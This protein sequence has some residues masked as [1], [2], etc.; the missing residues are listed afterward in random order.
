MRKSIYICLLWLFTTATLSAQISVSGTVIDV[1]D[2]QTIIGVNIIEAGTSNGTISDID[3]NFSMNVKDEN[4]V[5]I[6]SYIGYT[7]KEVIVGQQR[8]FN[9]SMSMSSTELEE[10]VII[11]Y[12][13]VKK[14][15]LT[16]SV[17]VIDSKVIDEIKPVKAEEALQ[18]TMTGVN[19]TQQSGAPGAG[20]DIRIRGIA[21]N[22]DGRPTVI[23]DGYEGDLSILNPK[24]IKS[25]S[26]LKDAQ[27]AIYG[28]RGANGVILITTNQGKKNTP[29]KVSVNSS[30]GT[31]ETSRKI[32]LLNATEYAALLN[33]SY[34]ASGQPLPY[35]DLSGLGEG[36]NW[37]DELFTTAPIYN[38]DF[39][40][41]K[42]SENM[43]FMISGSN[44]NQEG[45][46]GKEKSGF[47]RSTGRIGFGADIADWLKLNTSIAY[48]HI[49]RNSFNEFGLGSV[50]FNAL[51][52]PSTIPVY[53]ADGD[54]FPAPSNLGIEII[55]PLQQISNT[56]NDYNLNKINGNIGLTTSFT[57][58]LS[59]TTRIGVNTANTNYKSFSKIVDYGGKV[60]D[61]SRSSVFQQ[62]E[63]FNDYTF[64]AF[65]NYNTSFADAHN[66]TVTI[67]NSVFKEWGNNLNA[68]GF[69]IPNNS[70][71]Y[72]DIGLA[73]GIS[74]T[75]TSGSWVYDQ[76]TLSYFT[77]MQYDFKG[78][79]LASVMLRRDASTKFGPDNAVAYFPSATLGWVVSKENFLEDNNAIDNLKVR[80]SYGL[81]GSD[82]IGS[83]LYNSLL[84]GEA[85]YVL[86]G[87]LVNGRA[88]GVLPNT[89]V[90]WEAAEKFDIGADL[91]L[92]NNRID[93][94][95]DYYN[96]K[97]NDL[98]IPGIPVSGILGTAA[99]GAGNPTINAGTVVNSG[100][101][102]SIG[103]KGGDP[104]NFSY[105]VNYN[106]TKLK[107]E[108]TQVDNGTGFLS[109][110]GFGV[111][112]PAPAYMEVGFPLG[113]FYGYESDGIFQNQA[114]VEAHP[115]QLA[116]GA[117]AAPGD[118]R[119]KDLNGDGKL[120]GDDRTNIGS[121]I[122][123]YVMGLNLTL[124]YKNFDFVAYAYSSLGNEIVRNYERVQPNVNRLKSSLDRWTGEGTST[125]VPRLTNAATANTIFSD[126]YVEDGSFLRIQRVQL[127]YKLPESLTKKIR[128]KDIRIYCSVNN[129]FTLTNYTGFDPAA[130]SGQSLGNGFDSGFY[131]AARTYTFGLNLNL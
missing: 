87:E 86:D 89:A 26:V 10:I 83:Y 27:A 22:G 106:I 121:P 80:A 62:R 65:I 101:E 85:T 98:L 57:K 44:V 17:A 114:E 37:Q 109:G 90:K 36:T 126:Y 51:N 39:S 117:N 34:A 12:G 21:T 95:F 6:F 5:L 4:S 50:L 8:V 41:S 113:Y 1:A 105:K 77:R 48:T 110:G 43:N 59:L 97:R 73:T 53:D 125:T 25:I 124:K 49:D 63:N 70:W 96:E 103:L 68:T 47:N 54:Y 115:S 42:G 45:I 74:S 30:I 46:I 52:M 129:L 33:E 18:G 60:F 35:T 75:I 40:I 7:S 116:L 76:R 72:A 102:F 81:L 67:G 32:P 100:L 14:K 118:L 120:D 128:T 127:G 78:K 108:V 64:D 55:N 29:T 123:D 69:D 3:G 2:N 61:I 16:G 9:I 131:P 71:D 23:I 111:G 79:Y 107:N 38:N 130:S 56:Y 20:L 92:F 28:T 13:S 19:V 91:Q 15:E 66:L 93:I 58:N 99:P 24:D 88:T 119:F 112:Q 122:P 104:S 82:R 31:Q 94:T 84:T 11:G